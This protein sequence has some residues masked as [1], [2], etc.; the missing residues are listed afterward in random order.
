MNQLLRIKT[1]APK[2]G[3]KVW[4][5]DQIRD[6]QIASPKEIFRYSFKGTNPDDPK[7]RLLEQAKT[8][9]LPMIYL[10]GT[11]RS[12]ASPHYNPIYPVYIVEWDIHSLSCSVA[13]G[14]RPQEG[15]LFLPPGVDERRYR[16]V[17]TKHRLH[18]SLFRERMIEAYAGRCALTGLPELRLVDAAHIIS[19]TE[20]ELGQPDIRNGICMSKI[21][22]AAFDSQLIGI[23]PDYRIHVG[24]SLLGLHDGP[25]LEQG[26]KA[27]E[28]KKIILPRHK[29][30]WPD[31]E[32][33]A[34]R[35]ETF[36][37]SS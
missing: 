4:Y 13:V 14:S 16:M 17:E 18:Q 24:P 22:H 21:H 10:Y 23:D 34:I 15:S 30:L 2:P 37:K 1:V 8:L 32:R 6:D 35:Y 26:L 25:M 12:G 27:L 5:L 33:L 36:R 28:G 19:D 20:K 31:R 3:G 29:E 7:N 9:K 11:N